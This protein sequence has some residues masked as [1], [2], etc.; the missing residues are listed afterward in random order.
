MGRST[1]Y[2]LYASRADL[3]DHH[4]DPED[5]R[6]H[7]VVMFDEAWD[8][9]PEMV[10]LADRMG[11]TAPALRVVTASAMTAAV[12]GGATLGVVPTLLARGD[13][14]Q[15]VGPEALPSRD[16]WLVMHEDL[17]RAPP[18][19]AVADFFVEIFDEALQ[20]AFDGSP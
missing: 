18:V 13:M 5:L 15:L 12:A 2:G 7:D 10:W 1:R 8:A 14:V 16:L 20:A 3:E 11:E 9:L 17:R 19:R 6:G 4:V